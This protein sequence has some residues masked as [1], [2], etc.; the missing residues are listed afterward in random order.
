M[1][2]P[3]MDKVTQSNAANAE[4]I[5]AKAEQMKAV[6]GELVVMVGDSRDGANQGCAELKS[7]YKVETHKGL[8]V[9][10]VTKISDRKTLKIYNR[11]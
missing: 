3:E 7:K 6:A 1:A 8:E 4:E 2:L 11:F 10:A 9:A 5:S